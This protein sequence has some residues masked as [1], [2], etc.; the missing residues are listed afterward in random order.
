M[1]YKLLTITI[2][3]PTKRACFTRHPNST[4]ETEV[5]VYQNLTDVVLAVKL[6]TRWSY[7]CPSNFH[8]TGGAFELL[9]EGVS[10]DCG[11]LG[12]GV[13]FLQDTLG[14][15]DI[16]ALG[17]ASDLDLVFSSVDLAFAGVNFIIIQSASVFATSPFAAIAAG[18]G[19]NDPRGNFV[20]SGDGHGWV[21]LTWRFHESGVR[22]LFSTLDA[23]E[24][25]LQKIESSGNRL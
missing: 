8:L 20:E 16:L 3:S 6:R 2:A 17:G 13:A 24:D 25:D 4:K 7:D 1:L 14:L 18:L 11:L 21:L 15:G 19:L 5:T 9:T 22:N 10:G 23:W 12:L